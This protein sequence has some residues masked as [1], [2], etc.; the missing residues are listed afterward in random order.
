MFLWVLF[1]S[2]CFWCIVFYSHWNWGSQGL[3]TFLENSQ[4]SMGA[5]IWIQV[6]LPPKPVL[7][8]TN[9]V[10]FPLLRTLLTL[11]GQQSG[12]ESLSHMKISVSLLEKSKSCSV[13]GRSNKKVKGP[14][15]FSHTHVHRL[16]ACLG[17]AQCFVLCGGISFNP[18]NN[19]LRPLPPFSW[20][21]K[22]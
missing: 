12:A 20:L 11:Q 14:S 15:A 5:R 9:I 16:K 18:H 8:S 1:M 3:R 6:G 2:N 22:G 7:L 17:H 13:G 19:P 10:L 21:K 4:W